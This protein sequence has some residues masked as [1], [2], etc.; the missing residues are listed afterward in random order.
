M[1]KNHRVLG[2][3]EGPCEYN[4]LMQEGV[5]GQGGEDGMR[6]SEKTATE[7]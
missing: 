7:R 3:S 2:C 5:C 6:K 1:C 4:R